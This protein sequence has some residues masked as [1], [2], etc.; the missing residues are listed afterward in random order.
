MKNLITIIGLIFRW[1]WKLLTAGASLAANLLFIG[2]ILLIISLFMRPPVTVPDGAALI[3]APKGD[4]VEEPTVISPFSHLINGF[5]G[6]PVPEE[7][8]LQDVLD[9]IQAAADDDRIQV[10]V[11]SLGKMG[12]SGLNQLRAIGLGIERFKESGKK[13]VAVDDQYGQGQYYLASFADEV[14][15]NPMGGVY[16]RGFGVF[17]LYVGELMNRLAV[18]FHVFKVGT[19]KSA[20][21]P[22]VRDS[23]SDEDREANQLWLDN[24]WGRFCADI[25]ANRGFEPQ[26]INIVI[27]NLPLY[28]RRADGSSSRMAL[29]ANLVDS[30]KTRPEMDDY[31]TSL[32]GRDAKGKTFKQIHFAD[33]LQ[34]VKRSHTAPAK[35]GDRVGII[36]ARGNI[37]YGEDI[38]GQIGSDSLCRRIRLARDDDRVKALVLRIDS[39]GGSAFASEQIR[40]ELL[41]LQRSGKPLVVSMGSMAASGAYWISAG[42][43]RIYASPFTLTGSIGIFGVFPTFDETMAKIGMSSDG[44]G[45]TKLAGAGNPAIPLAPE[46]GEA[47]QLGVE[48]GYGR[49]ISI[50]AE[51]RDMEA[52]KVH[53]LAEGRVWDG[54]TARE[55]GLVDELGDLEDAVAAAAKLAGTE[56]FTTVLIRES[57]PAFGLLR[58]FGSGSAVNSAL[59][60]LRPLAV[61][62]WLRGLQQQMEVFS[63]G[64]D[65]A[66]I[67]AHCLLPRPAVAF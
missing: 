2:F 56:D 66:D 65:P 22:L 53:E 8:L 11:L 34:T 40:Q 27:N 30:L 31:L 64:G 19:Y 15:L 18:R 50:V 67:Y 5:A 60:L 17:R 46:L 49:F 16:L 26:F 25:A 4:I 33:Y 43:D 10:L 48:E 55:L 47:I 24:L 42:A 44:T 20:V 58:K 51:G 1:F 39:G 35:Q 29:E 38:P 32:V 14:L 54:V 7:T 61:P 12:H 57:D 59:P 62:A 52:Q 28:L 21:E 37:V 23:M 36:V 6:L 3:I 45:T 41:L 9:A 63:L 13:V